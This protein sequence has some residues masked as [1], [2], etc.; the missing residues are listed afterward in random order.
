M[1]KM[2]KNILKYFKSFRCIID[3]LLK[4]TTIT[5]NSKDKE[6]ITAETERNISTDLFLSMF[7]DV[8]SKSF[9]DSNTE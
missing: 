5:K 3:L 4:I 8:K 1:A 9:L 7:S 6:F 2:F